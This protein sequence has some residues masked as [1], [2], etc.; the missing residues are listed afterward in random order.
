MI[1]NAALSRADLV[2]TL[3]PFAVSRDGRLVPRDD[4]VRPAL[5]FAWRGR[6]CE[7]VMQDDR[8]HLRAIAGRIPST[9]ERGA[10]RG[11]TFRKVAGLPAEMPPGW[12]LTLTADHRIAVEMDAPHGTTA[13]AVLSEMVRFAMALD[14]YL[15]RLESAGARALSA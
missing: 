14:P 1:N 4:Q 10:D 3:G 12:R 2:T 6:S 15:D 9:A 11:Y 13:V 7:A 5:R 8:L